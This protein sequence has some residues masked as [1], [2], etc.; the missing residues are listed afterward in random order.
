MNIFQ[1]AK[2]LFHRTPRDVREEL[3]EA[4]KP[5]PAL[6]LPGI[7][8]YGFRSQLVPLSNGADRWDA[9]LHHFYGVRIS[10]AE[11]KRARRRERNLTW[12]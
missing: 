10:S 7:G 8:W 11:A 6:T 3:E 4:A 9:D 12:R 1:R 2:A 5:R